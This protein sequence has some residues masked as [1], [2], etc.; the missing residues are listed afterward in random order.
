M[1][2]STME[3]QQT[4]FLHGFC[5]ANYV[6]DQDDHKSSTGYVFI[7]GNVTITLCS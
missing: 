6:G 4:P 2:F 5:D 7:F 3:L 1:A